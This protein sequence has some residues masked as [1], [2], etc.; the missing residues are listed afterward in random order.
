MIILMFGT[1]IY[2]TSFIFYL[3][4]YG[5]NSCQSYLMLENIVLKRYFQYFSISD[6]KVFVVNID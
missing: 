5:F 6:L 3:K 1:R 2:Y 4:A